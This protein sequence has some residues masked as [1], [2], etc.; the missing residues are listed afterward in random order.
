MLA[1]RLKDV[2][3]MTADCEADIKLET[4][5]ESCTAAGMNDVNTR[6]TAGIPHINIFCNPGAILLTP[7]SP[8][9]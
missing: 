8:P 6:E 1:Q 3:L 2:F 7:D 9:F 4:K 5:N